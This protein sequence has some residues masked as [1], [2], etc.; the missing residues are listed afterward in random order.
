MANIYQGTKAPIEKS[1]PAPRFG[2]VVGAAFNESITSRLLA[3]AVDTLVARGVPSEDIDVAWVPGAFEIPTVAAQFASAGS[4]KAV[5]CLGCVIRGET[6]HDR[7]INDAVSH[8]LA[9]LGAEASL[10]VLFGILTCETLEQAVARSGGLVATTGKD[11]DGA[12]VG[13]KGVDCAEAALEMVSLMA[14]LEAAHKS[15]GKSERKFGFA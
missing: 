8:A 13:N 10:P 7:Y 12:H 11:A 3:G 15:A 6:S 5:I 2:I 9:R 4:Y 14:Q 1:E